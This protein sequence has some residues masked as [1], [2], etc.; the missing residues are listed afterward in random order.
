MLDEGVR[1]LSGESIE[2]A[3]ATDTTQVV[4]VPRFGNGVAAAV[5]KT[6]FILGLVAE[7]LL[8]LSGA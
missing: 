4:L 2:S 3:T 7:A 6:A 8:D 1:I 5:N